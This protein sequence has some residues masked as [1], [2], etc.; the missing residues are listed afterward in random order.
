[1]PLESDEEWLDAAHGE[2]PMRYYTYDN[3]I[4][5]GEPVPGLAAC[6]LIEELNLMST[7][8]PCTFAEAEQ[9]AAWRAMMQEEIDSVER[10]RTWELAD[11]PQGH[12]A[13]T[14]KWVYKLKRNE[15]GEIVKHKARLV[16]PGFVQQE[17][18]DFDE[19]FAPVTR[20]ESVRLLLMLAAQEG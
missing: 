2:S 16:V 14:L 19:V 6:N 3:I 13:I 10:N 4:G 17:G 11:L 12:R 9:D 5:V 18:I 20:M 8:E 15:A 1:M 7:G